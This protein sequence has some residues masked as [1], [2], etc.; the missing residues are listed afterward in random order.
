MSGRVTMRDVARAAGVS[1]MT[2]SR[3]LREDSTVNAKTRTAVRKAADRLGYVYD[4]TAQAFRAQRS[5]F[6]AVTLPSIN[7]ANFA[8][9]HRALTSALSETGLQI[10]LGI[11]DYDIEEEERHVR[12]LLARRPEGIILTGGAHT[13]QTLNLICA[14]DIPVVE[15]WDQPEQPLGH[16]V[17][18]SN[19]D[20]IGQIVGH[21]AERGHR[22]LGFIGASDESDRRGAERYR[23]AKAAAETLGLTMRFLDAGPAPISM[24][25]GAN[26]VKAADLSDIDA[27][28][29][30]SDPVAFG[31]VSAC[32]QMGMRVPEDIA[33]TGFGA[34]EIATVSVP[35]LT[36][37]DV[38]A[39]K[40][41]RTAGEIVSQVLRG[42]GTLGQ[43]ERIDTGSVLR[44]GGS[45]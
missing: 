29:C 27:L 36:T 20:A 40:I 33:V 3:A 34:F 19:T 41:G 12:Q 17:G 7:N 31:A 22:R 26:A 43:V 5:G 28:V 8:A 42:Q 10:L 23:G 38:F 39:D 4:T 32:I 44:V 2:V 15:I 13:Q 24:T 18:F 6:L 16:V 21:L 1:P 30:V 35:T 25:G 45:S 9:T 14:L 11:T 37:V